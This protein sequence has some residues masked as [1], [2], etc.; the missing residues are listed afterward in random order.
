MRNRE[1]FTL[2][3]LIAVIAL[4]ALVTMLIVPGL[5]NLLNSNRS[6]QYQ[7]YEDMMV[8]TTKTYPNYRNKAYVCLKQLNMQQVNQ[9]IDCNGYVKVSG[10]KLTPYLRCLENG[11]EIYKSAGYALPSDC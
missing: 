5:N 1:G 2:V 9:N 10:N 7:T 3:E 4:L 8:E 6:K 11:Q